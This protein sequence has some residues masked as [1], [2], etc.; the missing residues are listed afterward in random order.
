MT[1]GSG[2][3]SG[4]GSGVG[5]EV[6]VAAASML[7]A[8]GSADAHHPAHAGTVLLAA[9]TRKCWRLYFVVDDRGKDADRFLLVVLRRSAGI[10]PCDRYSL[11][12]A[13]AVDGHSHSAA[14]AAARAWTAPGARLRGWV[15]VS[16]SLKPGSPASCQCG[17][18][19]I[20]Y[21]CSLSFAHGENGDIVML[22]RSAARH[23]RAR[24]STLGRCMLLLKHAGA[25]VSVYP[26]P[27]A[28]CTGRQSKEVSCRPSP[29]RIRSRPYRSE[30]CRPCRHSL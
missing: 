10:G 17:Q 21:S 15:T 26:L 22:A 29:S 2:V 4:V 1:A 24:V 19:G 14:E 12:A 27:A 3:D 9:R 20:I 18:V 5:S 16:S 25:T 30:G 13:E 7:S 11:T 6:A 8:S 23:C 28:P